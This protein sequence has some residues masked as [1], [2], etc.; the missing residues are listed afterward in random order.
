MCLM[1]QQSP[2]KHGQPT[3]DST[4]AS[5]VEELV[6]FSPLL[7]VSFTQNYHNLDICLFHLKLLLISVHFRLS[8]SQ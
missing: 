6:R 7:T 4:R 3:L 5:K 2:V 8:Y 1:N